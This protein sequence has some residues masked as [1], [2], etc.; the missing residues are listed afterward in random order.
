VRCGD[1]G[2][3]VD[4]GDDLGDFVD[5]VLT[6]CSMGIVGELD[7]HEEFGD[8]DR[9]DCHLVVVGDEFLERRSRAVGVD[10]EGGVEEKSTQGRVSILRSPR[11]AAMSFAKSRS[12]P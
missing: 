4:N 11:A 12:R 6:S 2:V 8:G 7:A 5:E 1:F 9:G 10:Q 3:V